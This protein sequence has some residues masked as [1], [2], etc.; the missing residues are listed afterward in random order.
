MA[1]DKRKMKGGKFMIG[2]LVVT[3][4]N[5]GIELVKSSELIIGHQ[6]KIDA[7]SLNHGD[8]INE[9]EQKVAKKSVELDDG[10]GVLVMVDL[11]GG[12]PCNV[13]GK[14]IKG[15]DNIECLTGVNLPMLIEAI[16]SRENNSLKDLVNIAKDSSLQG[17]KDLRSLMFN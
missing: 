9:L 4:G 11:L 7:L 3:H 15:S 1:N 16:A 2:I 5:A 8:D 14:N 6:E 10:S 13:T 17:I 12:S